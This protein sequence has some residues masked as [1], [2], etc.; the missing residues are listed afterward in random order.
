MPF[1]SK[2]QQGYLFANKPQVAQEFASATPASAYKTL[3]QTAPKPKVA[4]KPVTVSPGGVPPK[5]TIKPK[6]RVLAP[7]GSP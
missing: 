7:A 3:P 2:K 4:G 6:S 1:V 5:R